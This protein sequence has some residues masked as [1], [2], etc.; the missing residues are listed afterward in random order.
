MGADALVSA[1]LSKKRLRAKSTVSSLL[2]VLVETWTPKELKEYDRVKLIYVDC[3]MKSAILASQSRG[4]SADS[5]SRLPPLISTLFASRWERER[6][7][8]RTARVVREFE[9]V[10][11]GGLF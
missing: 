3:P 9:T 11:M 2:S 8:R 6:A 1:P 5:D 4:K 7:E 10:A